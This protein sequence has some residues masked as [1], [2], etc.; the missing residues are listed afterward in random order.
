[1]PRIM[2]STIETLTLKNVKDDDVDAKDVFVNSADDEQSSTEN[3][4]DPASHISQTPRIRFIEIME[5]YHNGTEE[6]RQEAI[7]KAINELHGLIFAIIKRSYHTYM[8]EHYDDMEQE[9]KIGVI[10]GLQKYDPQISMP[11][12]WFYP[13][14]QH[15]IQNFI[16]VNVIRTTAHYSAN[17]RKIDKAI[18]RLEDLGIEYTNVE[19]SIQTGLTLETVNQAM[20]IRNCRNEVYYDACPEAVLNDVAISAENTSPEDIVIAKETGTMMYDALNNSLSADERAVIMLSFG[21]GD[22]GKPMSNK[23]IANVLH[24]PIDKVKRLH[25]TAMRKLRNSPLKNAFRDHLS[26]EEP[27]ISASEIP[28]MSTS[29]ADKDIV[30]LEMV[31]IDF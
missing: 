8:S 11:S 18:Q 10:K 29:V 30:W 21:L 27:I 2:N 28:L 24:M 4:I 6:E 3:A 31:D 9:G 12:T 7:C 13:Y 5:K 15:E 19:L 20:A 1:M 22:A 23:N 25:M 16:D 17:L 14:I 26:E